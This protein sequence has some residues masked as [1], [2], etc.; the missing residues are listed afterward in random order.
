MFKFTSLREFKKLNYVPVGLGEKEF[1]SH[2]LRDNTGDNISDKTL[3]WRVFILLLALEK[4]V[5][6]N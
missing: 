3:L 1:S 6:R 2:W 5:K 4:L